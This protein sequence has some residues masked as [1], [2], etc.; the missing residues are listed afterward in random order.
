VEATTTAGKTIVEYKNMEF[1]DIPDSTFELP[2]GV[3]II[4]QPGQ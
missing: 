2:P 4:Q 1:V 3:E